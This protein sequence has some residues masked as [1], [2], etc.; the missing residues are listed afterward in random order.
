V[1]VCGCVGITRVTQMRASLPQAPCKHSQRD[2]LL[3]TTLHGKTESV[4]KQGL[5]NFFHYTSFGCLILPPKDNSVL[6]ILQ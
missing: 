2:L 1:S 6:K 5:S 3:P 4:R